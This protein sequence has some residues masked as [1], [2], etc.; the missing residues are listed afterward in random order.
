[1]LLRT[2]SYIACRAGTV[3]WRYPATKTSTGHER[4]AD[5]IVGHMNHPHL[6]AAVRP[7]ARVASDAI[8]INQVHGSR[9]CQVYLNRAL[10]ETAHVY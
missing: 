8:G 9:Y 1:M 6:C 3:E 5:V 7:H 10:E 2:H 4:T